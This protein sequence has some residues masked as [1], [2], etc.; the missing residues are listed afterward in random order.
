MK[1]IKERH[2]FNSQIFQSNYS[3]GAS[4]LVTIIVVFILACHTASC[5]WYFV[6]K[7]GPSELSW[8]TREG[9]EDESKATIY[10]AGIYFSIATFTTV[11]YGDLAARTPYEMILSSI[12]MVFGVI[13]YSLLIGSLS[14]MIYS[15]DTTEKVLREKLRTLDLIRKDYGVSFEL[16]WKLRQS[17]QFDY[18]QDRGDR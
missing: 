18:L 2:K 16:Y 4:R 6:G 8:I 17:L 5:M 13:S 9:F 1:F 10:M 15:A 3:T 7:S 14:S 11:G 12:L